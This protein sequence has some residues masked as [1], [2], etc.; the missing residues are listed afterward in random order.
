MVH[1][2]P[3]EAT[4]RSAMGCAAIDDKAS[5]DLASEAS[6]LLH[7]LNEL[8]C[9]EGSG[10]DP[11]RLRFIES[12][13]CRAAAQRTNVRQRLES[14]AQQ[15][16]E[17]YKLSMDA[18]SVNAETS[19]ITPYSKELSS[20]NLSS[21]GLADDVLIALSTLNQY[22]T[23][24]FSDEIL[25]QEPLPKKL[26]GSNT[27]SESSDVAARF[28]GSSADTSNKSFAEQLKQQEQVIRRE[29][30]N[31]CAN[32]DEAAVSG[33]GVNL[34]TIMV[35]KSSLAYQKFQNKMRVDNFID[36]ALSEIPE[37]PG[38]LN[39]EMLAIRLLKNIRTISP[40]YLSRYVSYFETLQC[41]EKA[42]S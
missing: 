26:S 9:Q 17:N 1:T 14:K 18:A 13:M 39:P 33:L 21:K 7:Q 23:E 22:L 29:C 27:S 20:K 16:L 11:A 37:T 24:S 6:V 28:T 34:P 32:V 19:L 31:S 40:E 30:D 41:L 25:S 2:I 38:P 10:Y 3:N 12:L 42:G 36:I 35:L 4:P 8:K 5:G 15:A